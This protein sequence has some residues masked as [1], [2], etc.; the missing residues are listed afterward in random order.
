MRV[1]SGDRHLL[2]LA[3]DLPVQTTRAFLDRLAD[4]SR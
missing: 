2:E 1:V 3:D 4:A